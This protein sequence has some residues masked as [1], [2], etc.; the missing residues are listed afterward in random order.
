MSQSSV[1]TQRQLKPAPHSAPPSVDR[2]TDRLEVLARELP[3]DPS[4]ADLLTLIQSDMRG[5]WI[6]GHPA[7]LEEYR[8]LLDQHAVSDEAWLKL[9]RCELT[10]QLE[11]GQTPLTSKYQQRFP[12]LLPRIEADLEELLQKIALPRPTDQ[13]VVRKSD[14]DTR[15]IRAVRATSSLLPEIPG[16]EILEAV[17]RGGMGIVFKARQTGLNRIVALKMIL[18]DTIPTE[19]DH[20]RFLQEAEAV[21]ALRHPNIV[22]IFEIGE[23]EGKPFFSLEY[24]A[25]GTLAALCHG[26]PQPSA[27]AAEIIATLAE[28]VHAAHEQNI[29]HRDLKP[30]NILLASDDS[31]S[32]LTGKIIPKITDFGLA[33]RLDSGKGLTATGVAAGTPVYMAPEQIS[34]RRGVISPATDVWALG[35]ILYEMVTGR[36]P[37]LA[38]NA[39]AVMNLVESSS[40]L[41]PRQLLPKIPRDLETICLKCLEKSPQKRYAA[42]SE[43]ADDLRRFSAG[44]PIRARRVSAFEQLWRWTHRNKVVTALLAGI[45]VVLVAGIVTATAFAIQAEQSAAVA[46]KEKR[47]ALEKERIARFNEEQ[48]FH[49]TEAAI[50]ARKEEERQKNAA[51]LL[52]IQAFEKE[53]IRTRELYAADATIA[54]QAWQNGQVHFAKGFLERYTPQRAS[55]PDLRGFEWYYIDRLCRSEIAING[56]TP[57]ICHSLAVTPDGRRI[58]FWLD[59]SV[60]MLE[61]RQRLHLAPLQGVSGD[62]GIVRTMA[63]DAKGERIAVGW[64]DGKLRIWNCATGKLLQTLAGHSCNILSAAFSPDGKTLASCAADGRKPGEI[65]LWDLQTNQPKQTRHTPDR[66]PTALAFSRDGNTLACGFASGQVLVFDAAM[67]KLIHTIPANLGGIYCLRF[68]PGGNQIVTGTSFGAIGCYDP[69]TGKLL[70]AIRGQDGA[71]LTL[72]FSDDGKLVA[73][74]CTDSIVRLWNFETGVQVRAFRGHLGGLTGVQFIPGTAIL[75]STGIDGKCH[76]WKTDESVENRPLVQSSIA[77]GAGEIRHAIQSP[78]RKKLLLGYWMRGCAWLDIA[79]GKLEPIALKLPEGEWALDLELFPDGDTVIANM[80]KSGPLLRS[81]TGKKV[82]LPPSVKH[83]P[84]RRLKL[85]RDGK[86]LVTVPDESHLQVH[87][88]DGSAPGVLLDFPSYSETLALS[89]GDDPVLAAASVDGKLHLFNAAS[90]KRVRLI[91]QLP[92]R[93]VS[94]GF[95]PNGRDLAGGGVLSHLCLWDARTGDE[96]WSKRAHNGSIVCIEFNP[97]G[98]RLLTASHDRTAKIFDPLTGREILGLRGSSTIVSHAFYTAEGDG[99]L[100]LDTDSILLWDASSSVR[101]EREHS[102]IA[103]CHIDNL[104]VEPTKA[105]GALKITFDLVNT[106]N[107]ELKLPIA[108]TPLD[109][110]RLIVLLEPKGKL[111]PLPLPTLG[112]GKY[113]LVDSTYP[114]NHDLPAGARIADQSLKGSTQFFP[115]GAYR[116]HIQQRFLDQQEGL[117]LVHETSTDVELR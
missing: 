59:R 57:A 34:A 79:S 93:L 52:K 6:A 78:D 74:G 3:L 27:F 15:V 41:L 87:R 72:A 101:R 68:A 82:A 25:G 38:D 13:V 66:W 40:P 14:L 96:K 16:Y 10:L 32:A 5:R 88:L 108:G 92:E 77:S 91:E 49:A 107:R 81:L 54:Y 31:K 89:S 63:L 84:G 9:I 39:V 105:G 35:I 83:L 36:P 80:M 42:A 85:S 56:I 64:D 44:R 37:F 115:A 70:R 8:P 62:F 98:D 43:L 116:L 100:T 76:F 12:H 30:S 18:S 86:W 58:F 103:G 51:N 11:S 1:K 94:L 102:L 112:S 24:V 50:E 75:A 48:A 99:L 19:E 23:H 109:K 114:I 7:W 29:V 95:S 67:E 4:V 73:S 33:K 71:V 53:A 61:D 111:A 60:V 17:G 113:C 97:A 55:D 65:I 47:N 90:G 2:P 106:L 45:F 117:K 28:A 21:A 20:L 22:Q 104:Q 69:A 46:E 26:K 110:M